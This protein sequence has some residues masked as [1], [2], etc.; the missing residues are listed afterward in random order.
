TTFQVT[1]A[2]YPLFVADGM[3]HAVDTVKGDEPQQGHVG[4]INFGVDGAALNGIESADTIRMNYTSGPTNSTALLN[5]KNWGHTVVVVMEAGSTLGNV[6]NEH[7]AMMQTPAT[8]KV[9]GEYV[10]RF[11]TNPIIHNAQL[12]TV[13]D[14]TGTDQSWQIIRASNATARASNPSFVPQITG[15]A[16]DEVRLIPIQDPQFMHE[17]QAG[18]PRG[19]YF[20][21]TTA[22][23]YGQ[24][25]SDLFAIQNNI[26]ITVNS[27]DVR[28]LVTAQENANLNSPAVDSD[29]ML[30]NW[31]FN[32]LSLGLRGT[33][34][35]YGINA[36]PGKGVR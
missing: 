29:N 34:I 20:R 30:V 12:T 10:L 33:G 26:T 23:T 35:A 16:S 14:S 21:L 24:V 32:R 9:A 19:T 22:G 27:D 8:N 6:T 5:T 28:A 15:D 1:P 36:H 2:D 17:A 11:T 18:V 31:F 13:G 7:M 3:G 25:A 4:S